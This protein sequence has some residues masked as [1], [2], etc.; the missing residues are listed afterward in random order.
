MG[1]IAGMPVPTE[2]NSL[3]APTAAPSV[4]AGANVHFLTQARALLSRLDDEIY[5]APSVLPMSP[6]GGHLRHCLDFYS[7]F[8]AGLENGRVDYDA[9]CR[10]PRVETDRAHALGVIDSLID[11]LGRLDAAEEAR[12]LQVAGDRG[13]GEEGGDAWSPSSVRRELQFLRSHTV[14]HFALIR[15]VL[16]LFDFETDPDF[17]VAPSTLTFRERQTTKSPA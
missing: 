15:A 7:C 4:L 5:A 10:D 3:S 16:H 11:R 13:P 12:S 6:V 8:L 14:H 9:R 17:G 1:K 2:P